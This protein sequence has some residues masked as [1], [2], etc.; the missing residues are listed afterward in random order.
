[1]TKTVVL[2]TIG[3]AMLALGGKAMAGNTHTINVQAT[4]ISEL[5]ITGTPGTLTVDSATAGQA[6]DAASTT[7]SSALAWTSNQS[8]K[9]IDVSASGISGSYGYTLNVKAV[10]CIRNGGASDPVAIGAGADLDGTYRDII[11][12]AGY[13]AAVCDLTYTLTV[14]V[15]QGAFGPETV[16]VD[17]IIADST[18]Y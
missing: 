10:N 4:T 11:Q 3:V 8:G 2:M 9:D 13:K 5:S 12:G 18:Q 16:T 14:P 6:P 1:M 15:T 7:V 17:F